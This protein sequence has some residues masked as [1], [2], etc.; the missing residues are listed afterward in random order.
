MANAPALRRRAA[1]P[2]NARR[3]H[4]TTTGLRNVVVYRPTKTAQLKL[5]A[6]AAKLPP[7]WET[8]RP[9]KLPKAEARFLR[10]TGQAV[11]RLFD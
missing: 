1:S 2:A 8:Y 6:R 11:A 3:G 9:L 4:V 5:H 7:G 10:E